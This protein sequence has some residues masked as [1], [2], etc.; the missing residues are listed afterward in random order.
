MENTELLGLIGDEMFIISYVTEKWS[1]EQLQEVTPVNEGVLDKMD[2]VISKAV[3][4]ES[5]K[6]PSVK[7]SKN[8]SQKKKNDMV[9]K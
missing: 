1:R 2:S 7:D 5:K 6:S 4:H 9:P 3:A 8:E